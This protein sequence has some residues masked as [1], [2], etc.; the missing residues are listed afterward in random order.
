MEAFE[1]SGGRCECTR[2]ACATHYLT[3]CS[4]RLSEST[5]VYNR[6][7]STGFGDMDR[8]SNCEVLCESCKANSGYDEFLKH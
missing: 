2:E 3:R 1:R 4:S 8:L 7:K 5:A 6:K